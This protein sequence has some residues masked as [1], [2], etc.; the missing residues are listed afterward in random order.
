MKKGDIVEI[1]TEYRCVFNG[2]I[3][4]GSIGIVSNKIISFGVNFYEV[5][6]IIPNRTGV[7]LSNLY[8]KL[9][10]D[11]DIRILKDLIEY[12]RYDIINNEIILNI[13]KEMRIKKNI[14][15]SNITNEYLKK[16]FRF[17][18]VNYNTRLGFIKD[19][20]VIQIYNKLFVKKQNNEYIEKNVKKYII[21]KS[22]LNSRELDYFDYNP[23]INECEV[24]IQSCDKSIELFKNAS[25]KKESVG[26][27]FKI[28]NIELQSK[29]YNSEKLE[30]SVWININNKNY[31]FALED[32]KILYPIQI[33]RMNPK[34]INIKKD[35]KI[36]IGSTVKCINHKKVSKF[37]KNDT[38]SVK[39]IKNIGNKTYIGIMDN[40]QIQYINKKYFKV[41]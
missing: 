16:V 20:Y 33:I 37:N 24:L 10:S 14:N 5:D 8:L 12:K 36:K 11:I 41:I 4:K 29:V 31:R 40:D 35:R 17:I 3:L 34:S 28:Q 9:R 19:N 32:V 2:T 39:N 15:K 21:N 38:I 25:I 7:T 27:I 23:I 22:Q 13:D 30:D 18:P 6:I 26:K 1:N